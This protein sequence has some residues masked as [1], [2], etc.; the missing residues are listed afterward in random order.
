[1]TD[2]P[3]REKRELADWIEA[4]GFTHFNL[5]YN[6]SREKQRGQIAMIVAALRAS[7]PADAPFTLQTPM[8]DF[9]KL[10][11]EE[12][13]QRQAAM[14]PDIERLAADLVAAGETETVLADAGMGE[15][16]KAL[17]AADEFL[18]TLSI[19]PENHVRLQ[20][21]SAIANIEKRSMSLADIMNEGIEKVARPLPPRDAVREALKDC[22]IYTTLSSNHGAS[23]HLEFKGVGRSQDADQL[24]AALTALAALPP[25]QEKPDASATE[26]VAWREAL[27]KIA[28]L[29]DERGEIGSTARAAL[30]ATPQRFDKTAELS[31]EWCDAFLKATGEWIDT[32]EPETECGVAM[33][34]EITQEFADE[35]NASAREQIR[36][37]YAAAC[38]VARPERGSK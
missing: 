37:G 16:R 38:A 11:A 19:F 27:E 29:T 30:T 13:L 12:A 14:Q 7:V 20:I 15:A 10:R 21:N 6:S 34:C 17:L 4:N 28:A 32:Y 33:E 1:M 8:T 5:P 25:A 26:P 24:M 31:D 35:L 3:T 9:S 2:D 23:V 22:S 18:H 36:K